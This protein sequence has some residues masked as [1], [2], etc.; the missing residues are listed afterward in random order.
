M[1]CSLIET[2]DDIYCCLKKSGTLAILLIPIVVSFIILVI[3]VAMIL[4]EFYILYLK[5]NS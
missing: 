5:M 2:K 3:T 1:I 4:S